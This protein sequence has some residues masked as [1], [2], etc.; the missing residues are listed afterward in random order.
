MATVYKFA[1]ERFFRALI[2]IARSGSAGAVLHLE[3]DRKCLRAFQKIEPLRDVVGMLSQAERL[4]NAQLRSKGAITEG[5]GEYRFVL[6]GS[7]DELIGES[8]K[9]IEALTQHPVCGEISWRGIL[10]RIFPGEPRR[11][12]WCD[13]GYGLA[14]IAAPA[15]VWVE[16]YPDDD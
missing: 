1:E 12:L 2:R 14:S 8:I 10:I 6:L 13:P 5:W 7:R 15:V 16:P 4:A 11:T 9:L 3:A